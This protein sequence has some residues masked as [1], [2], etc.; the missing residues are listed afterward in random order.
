[1]YIYSIHNIC[2]E[3]TDF[4]YLEGDKLNSTPTIMHESKTPIDHA[5][6]YQR[7]YRLP[8]SQRDEINRQINKMNVEGMIEPDNFP[9]NSSMLLVPK[10]L[11]ATGKLKYC[12]VLN[13]RKLNNMTVGDEMPLLQIRD[14]LDH[15]GKSKYFTV[16][17]FASGFHQ[18]P[19]DE[20]SK[21]KSGFSSDIGHWHYTK[22]PMGLKNSP[23]TFQRFMN[24]VLCNVIG[25]Q[26]LV[27]LD[28]IVIFSVD[29]REHTKRLRE[30]F[31]HLRAYTLKLNPAKCEFSSK[32]VIYLGHKLSEFGVQPDEQ[33]V[34]KMFLY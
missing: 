7:Q 31:N 12:L 19:L 25:S 10:K 32:K 6:I 21:I 1:M 22:L 24:N 5:P 2:S 14:V 4:F 9:W 33:K 26:C 15:S 18:I 29:I 28:D 8:H 3:Y 20:S 17:D 30:V 13:Y 11:D 34:L 27:Y 16:L 23:P